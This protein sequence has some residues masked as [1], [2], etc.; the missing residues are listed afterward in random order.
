MKIILGM[1]DAGTSLFQHLFVK[2]RSQT[3]REQFTVIFGTMKAVT[4]RSE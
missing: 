3:E 1:I 4:V 2:K